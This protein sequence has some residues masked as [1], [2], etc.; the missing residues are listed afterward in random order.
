ML[1]RANVMKVMI[2]ILMLVLFLVP[3]L[4]YADWSVGVSLGGPGYYH[5]RDDHHYY[6]WHDHPHYGWHMHHLPPGYYTIWVDGIKYYYYD[7]LYYSY[8]GDGDF[9]LVNPP[10]GAYVSAIPPDFQAMIVNGRTYYTNNG[11]YYV[12]TDRGYRVVHPPDVYQQPPVEIVAQPQ[13][14]VVAAPASAPEVAQD[15]FPI[16]IP[17]N[18]GGYTAVVIKKSG[19]GYVGPQGEF[20]PTFPSVAQLKAMYGK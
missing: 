19:T 9:V 13:Q 16:N 6:G 18:N 12:F 20:Y 11:V 3:R 8:A 17:N 7:G 1:S 10:Y 15:S 14:V 5:D 4:S 2:G